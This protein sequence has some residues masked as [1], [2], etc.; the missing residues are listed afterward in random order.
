M[1]R[2]VHIALVSL[3]FSLVSTL[4]IYFIAYISNLDYESGF[5][6]LFLCVSFSFA[7]LFFYFSY[8][9]SLNRRIKNIT[10]RVK[11]LSKREQEPPQILVN[12]PEEKPDPLRELDD[13]I[14]HLEAVRQE[15][16]EKLLKLENHRKEFLGNVSHELKT[17]IFNIQGYVSTLIDGGIYDESINMEYLKRADKS[18]DRM[19]HIVGDLEQISQLES[20]VLELDYEIF[21]MSELIRDVFTSLEIQAQSRKIQL[22]MLNPEM[23]NVFVVA[24]KFRIRQV[25]VNLITNSIKY[26]KEN[27][28]TVI[29]F[30]VKD[31]KVSVFV[32]DNGI[33]IEEVHL[34]RLFERFYRVDKG[35][36]RAQGGSGL[37]LAIVKH[38]IEAH[39]QQIKV[40]SK[41]GEGTTF[42]FGLTAGNAQKIN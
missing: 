15:E 13:E 31:D 36:S 1:H 16:I 42:T 33:G 39:H 29:D 27:G 40:S 5:L 37:G 7:W 32:S 28:K 14:N 20:G 18:V 38:I 3:L 25:L 11:I 21:D 19:I 6:L 35:R 8:E 12:L 9:L 41:V 30:L 34:P 26:G 22:E 23:Q 2:S 10:D 24:D 4:A 17:P